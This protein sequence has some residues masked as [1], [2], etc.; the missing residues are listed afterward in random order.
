MSNTPLAA[1]QFFSSTQNTERGAIMVLQTL[2]DRQGLRFIVAVDGECRLLQCVILALLLELAIAARKRHGGWLPVHA[3]RSAAGDSTY[4]RKL[5][6]R[7]NQ[8]AGVRIVETSRSHFRLL[9]SIE[10]EISDDATSLLESF[11][12]VEILA[13]LR[14][15]YEH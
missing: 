5:V 7:L 8:Q 1:N 12:D 10:I 9:P 13:D 11:V 6:S 2:G 14:D 3:I 4:A 15:A